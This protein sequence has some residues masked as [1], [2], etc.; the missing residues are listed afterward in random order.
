MI[1]LG[2]RDINIEILPPNNQYLA[3]LNNYFNEKSYLSD[4]LNKGYREIYI[5]FLSFGLATEVPKLT[6]YGVVLF[7]PRA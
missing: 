5:F 1:T 7:H 3:E 4:D 2:G 6:N